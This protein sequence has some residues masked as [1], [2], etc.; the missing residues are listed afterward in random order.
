MTNGQGSTLEDPTEIMTT[1]VEI[2]HQTTGSG[3]TSS[4][5]RAAGFYFQCA[6]V[7][8]G[9]VG[10]AAN[11]LILYAM[12]VSKQHKKQ[13]L[14][15]NQNLLDFFSCFFLFTT[16]AVK[17]GN[18]YLS[19]TLGFWLCVAI[20]GELLNWG[21]FLGSLMNLGAI[22]VERYLKIVHHAWAKKKLRA[23]TIYSVIPLTWIAGYIIAVG[24][25]IHTSRVVDGNCY[26]MVFWNSRA[27]QAA[28]GIW[29]FLSF[30]VVLLIIFAF[31]Y[32]RILIKVRRQ[33][34]L[35][36]GH[37][38]PTASH[39]RPR[40]SYSIS[41]PAMVVLQHQASLRRASWPAMVVLQH[42]AP[43]KPSRSRFRPRSSRR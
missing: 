43:L 29:Y 25:T 9:F 8:I 21:A 3:M 40:W 14:I 27:A 4:S 7:V 2:N 10:A 42:Q 1:L 17:L 36:A 12:V 20:F 16:H 35:M 37:G 24:V 38:G 28:F 31:G 22:T 23:W 19:G 39:G 32:G 34:S 15:F 13:V 30:Y 26:T 11:G 5:S 6:V 18:V 41:W 33:A